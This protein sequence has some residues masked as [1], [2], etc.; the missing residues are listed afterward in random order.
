MR[1]YGLFATRFSF[2]HNEVLLLLLLLL[3][4]KTMLTLVAS[5][6]AKK[7]HSHH[8]GGVHSIIILIGSHPPS[9][10]HCRPIDDGAGYAADDAAHHTATSG[11]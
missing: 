11:R 3:P 10:S 8:V 7:S 2:L 6:N 9:F 4:I 5:A 1:F